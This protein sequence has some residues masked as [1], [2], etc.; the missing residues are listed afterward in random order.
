V[1][2]GKDACFILGDHVGLAKA[3]EKL[4]KKLDVKRVSLGKIEYLASHCITI[5]NYEID[6]FL[7]K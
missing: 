3:T 7:L 4:L 1:K 2:F 6:K 5:C